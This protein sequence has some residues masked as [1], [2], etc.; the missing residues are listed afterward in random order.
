MSNPLRTSV[1]LAS[2]QN[3]LREGGVN[4]QTIERL[5]QVFSRTV[6]VDPRRPFRD[7]GEPRYEIIFVRSGVLSMFKVDGGGARQI[8]ALRYPGDGILPSEGTVDYGVGAI[9]RSVVDIGRADD[10]EAVV[11]SC[12]QLQRLVRKGIERQLSIG[13]EWLT[14]FGR[15]DAAAR[16]AHL[17]CETAVRCDGVRQQALVNPFTQQQI[18]EITG[19]TSVNVNRVFAELHKTG[20]I[21]KVGRRIEVDDWQELCRLGSFNADYLERPR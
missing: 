2:L 14:N 13:Y 12:P 1:T 20:L 6:T 15:L 21:R 8:N 10:F 7:P 17:L 19:Q 5:V 4:S 9:T 3:R 18:A 11:D 16:V